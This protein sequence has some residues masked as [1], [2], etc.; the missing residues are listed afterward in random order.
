MG[1]R[2]ILAE[3]EVELIPDDIQAHAMIRRASEV[4]RRR[5][6]QMLLD[7]NHHHAAMKDLADRERRGRPDITQYCLLTLLESPLNRAGGLDVAIHTR[8]N[9]LVFIR[10]DTRL[11][12]GEA[13]FQGV[14]AKV[15]FEGASQDKDPLIWVEGRMAPEQVLEK[16]AKGPVLRLDE[17]GPFASPLQLVDQAKRGD[18]T[19]VLGAFPSGAWSEPWRRAAPRTVSIWPEPLNAWAVASEVVTAFRARHGPHR[20]G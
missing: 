14:M 10:P 7:Q 20:P 12:R 4:Q 8:N 18:L 16:F 19:L 5:A 2:V 15:L 3:A 17:T 13:R 6:S 1:L 9:R 11:P